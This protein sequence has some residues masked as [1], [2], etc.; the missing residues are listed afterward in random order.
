MTPKSPATSD[1]AKRTRN[2]WLMI[3]V[4]F[5]A[6]LAFAGID[7]LGGPSNTPFIGLPYAL[8]GV[9][10]VSAALVWRKRVTAGVWLVIVG[11]L[12]ALF[13]ST[14]LVQG[15]ALIFSV[16]GLI[17]ISAIASLALPVSQRSWALMAAVGTGVAAFLVD[18][19]GPANRPSVGNT[20]TTLLV[21]ALLVLVFL[22]LQW[23]TLNAAVGRLAYPQKFVL[24]SLLFILPLATFYPLVAELLSQVDHYGYK[25]LH[26]TYYLRP[27]QVLLSQV[28]AHARLDVD[29]RTEIATQADLTRLESVIDQ[30]FQVVEA[31]HRQYGAE[32]QITTEVTNLK[33][34][35]AK[36]KA[37]AASLTK[38]QSADEH[39]LIEASTRRLISRVGDTS[40]LILDPD[41][42]TYY[43]MDAVLLKLPESQTLLHQISGLVRHA[44][45]SGQMSASDRT[46][47]IIVTGLLRANVDAMDQNLDTSFRNNQSGAMRPLVQSPRGAYGTAIR[48]L[49]ILLEARLIVPPEPRLDLIEFSTLADGALAG[50]AALY[51]AASQALEQG[52][53]IRITEVTNRTI[54]PIPFAVLTVIVAFLGGLAMMRSIS[55]PLSALAQAAQR[56]GVGDLSARVPVTTS[57]EVGRAGNAFNDMAQDLQL[58]NASLEA[59]TRAL[60]TS[61]EVS[62]RLSTILN[63]EDLVREVANQVR[64]AF[65]YYHAQIYLFDEARQNLVIAGGTGDAGRVMLAR[66]HKI[67]QGRGLVGR[68]AGTN[69]VVLVPNTATDMGWLPNP[70]LPLTKAELAVPIALGGNVLG[71]LDVQHDVIDGLTQAD[72]DVLQSIAN[73]VAVGLQNARSFTAAQRR[74]EREAAVVAISQKIQSATTPEAVLQVAAQEL[75]KTLNARRATAQ[76]SLPKGGNGETVK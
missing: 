21:L 36:L 66:G 26:G 31:V 11:V 48:Q 29:Y 46:N 38:S 63:Q 76:I 13:A 30:Q 19:F 17:I 70:L 28:Q 24:I 14:L 33:A 27:L 15:L 55:R 12:G 53:Q 42:D 23:R 37:Q 16:S 43:M 8:L 5:V 75:G 69:Q 35:W 65:N 61:A 56:L 3:G 60:A 57:D 73:Q 18:V 39:S 52:I 20:S 10:L 62:R 6:M 1:E 41:L 40:Y 45:I 32:L 71:V 25:E 67:P 22:A 74:A 7:V 51:D 72:A 2:A 50:N 59:R 58:K 9:L 54:L 47:L 44:L 34:D 4:L 64:S 68:A 49:L